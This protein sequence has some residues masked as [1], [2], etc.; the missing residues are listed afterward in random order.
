MLFQGTC[1]RCCI[2]TLMA[3]ELL[4]FVMYCQDMLLQVTGPGCYIFTFSAFKFLYWLVLLLHIE[5]LVQILIRWE[6]FCCSVPEC[7]WFNILIQS[8]LPG[9][10]LIWT[11]ASPPS[12]FGDALSQSNFQFNPREGEGSRQPVRRQLYHQIRNWNRNHI[13]EE[14]STVHNASSKKCDTWHVRGRQ[15]WETS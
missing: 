7:S 9:K 14:E 10:H 5:P 13:A 11:L 6:P 4:S 15:S 2:V 12:F 8:S 3:L 1:L